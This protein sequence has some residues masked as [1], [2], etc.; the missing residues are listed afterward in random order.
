[1]IISENY[2]TCVLLYH[3]YQRNWPV[4][5]HNKLT[6]AYLAIVKF[7]LHVTSLIVLPQV[8]TF[9]PQRVTRTMML[10]SI[11]ILIK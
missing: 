11:E 7:I 10:N 9:D 1:M 2:I 4:S 3:S 6:I 8:S 5:S